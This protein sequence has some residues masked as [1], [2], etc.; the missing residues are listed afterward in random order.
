MLLKIMFWNGDVN[1][2]KIQE[3]NY[4]YSLQ[5][6]IVNSIVSILCLHAKHMCFLIEN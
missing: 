3:E 6:T 2:K 5:L 1:K 4:N